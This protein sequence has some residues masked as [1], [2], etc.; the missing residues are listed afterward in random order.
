M[1]TQTIP[2]NDV[3][4]GY[5]L[6]V[7]PAEHEALIECR[8][9]TSKMSTAKM[10]I[11]PEQGHFMSFLVKLIGASKALE[12][13]VFTGYSSTAVALVLP[14]DGKLIACDRNA[15]W[16]K[17][18]KKTWAKAGV[19]EKVELKIG[20]AADTLHQLIDEGQAG[21]FDFVFIDADKKSYDLYY[22]LCLELLR[23][24]G[25]M[26]LD[27]MFYGGEAANPVSENSIIINELNGKVKNDSRV[28]SCFVPI[29]DG[30]M[31]VQRN[32]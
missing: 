7:S 23:P 16:T 15:E 9:A 30:V 1:S 27:N 31:M 12:V 22:E 32:S 29:G 11:S 2:M 21:S 10:Q 18:A 28:N 8:Q 19:E 24:G 5:L 14:E 6:S 20:E 26:L 17:L 4:Y 13:G 3:L 25:L